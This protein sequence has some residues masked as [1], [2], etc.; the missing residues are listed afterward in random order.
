MSS[1]ELDGVVS[2]VLVA[3]G[4]TLPQISFLFDLPTTSTFNRLLNDNL[5]AAL[6]WRGMVAAQLPISRNWL[7]AISASQLPR[8]NVESDTITVKCSIK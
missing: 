1:N 3:I 6:T 2:N 8:G 7:L 5:L 4:F